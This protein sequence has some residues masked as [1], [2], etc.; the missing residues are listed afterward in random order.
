M[1]TY[2]TGLRGETLYKAEINDDDNVTL[3]KHFAG[4]YG[5]LRA[6]AVRDNEL[7]FSTS[8]RDGRGS[9]VNDDDRIFAVPLRTLLD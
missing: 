5:R 4:E 6:V 8:N 2:F 7:F 1:R 3:T 9:P